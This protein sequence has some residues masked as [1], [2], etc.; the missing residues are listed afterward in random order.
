MTHDQ[1]AR[2]LPAL[3]SKMLLAFA[4]EFDRR[5]PAPLALCVNVLR[6]VSDEGVR[7]S[8]L[9]TLTGGSPEVRAI[10]WRSETVRGGRHCDGPRKGRASQAGRRG[11]ADR[12]STPAGRPRNAVAGTVRTGGRERSLPIAGSALRSGWRWTFA[13]CDRLDST[14]KRASIGRTCRGVW[15]ARS[16][17]GR[18]QT[19]ARDGR[20]DRRVRRRSWWQPA[21]LSTVGHEPRIRTIGFGYP[22]NRIDRAEPRRPTPSSEAVDRLDTAR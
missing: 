18:A 6:V 11:N 20:P 13:H 17:S 7:V 21:T 1:T 22:S 9:A 4:V 5:S 8:D 16:A 19:D 12:L 15:S 10:G 2:P 14:R 3:L